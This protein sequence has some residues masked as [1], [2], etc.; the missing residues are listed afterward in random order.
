M[1]TVGRK[2]PIR[3]TAGMTSNGRREANATG[4]RGETRRLNAGDVDND[5]MLRSR[6]QSG[7]LKSRDLMALEALMADVGDPVWTFGPTSAALQGADGFVLCKPFHLLTLRGRNITR[8]GHVIHT[9]HTLDEIDRET[10]R[11]IATTAPARTII[12]LVRCEP[13]KRVTAALDSALR[14]GGITE[15][16]LHSR[17]AALRSSGRH[18]IPEL[19]RIIEGSELSRGGHSWLERRFLEIIGEAGLPRPTPQEVLTRAKNRLV[20]VDCRFPGTHLVVELLGYQYHRTPSQLQRDAERMN[21]LGIDGFMVLQFTYLHVTEEP[22]WVVEQVRQA[23]SATAM[24][25]TRPTSSLL[26]KSR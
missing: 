25:G 20:R 19:L 10:V 3:L 15:H 17:I 16:H 12:D 4:Q 1:P 23:L 9:T 22:D 14:D 21:H 6:V 2:R 7:N 13:A 18:G 5:V 8:V 24:A 26:E 11:S